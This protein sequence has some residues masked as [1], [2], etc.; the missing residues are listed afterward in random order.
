MNRLE[1]TELAASVVASRAGMRLRLL[2]CCGTPCVAAGAE[3]V[4]AAIR[5]RLAAAGIKGEGS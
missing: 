3:A 2:V 5:E 1:L 4:V